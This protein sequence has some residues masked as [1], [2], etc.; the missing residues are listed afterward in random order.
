MET[1]DS[2]PPLLDAPPP[3]L[4]DF[5]FPDSSDDLPDAIP[6]APRRVVPRER[7]RRPPVE[8]RRARRSAPTALLVALPH[9]ATALLAVAALVVGAGFGLPTPAGAALVVAVGQSVGLALARLAGQD[10]VAR[11]WTVDLLVTLALV[12]LASL[13]VYLTQEPY[14]DFGQ[15]PSVR[16]PLLAAT[17]ATVAVLLV[18]AGWSAFVSRAD[19]EHASLLFLPAA[20]AAT[21]VLGTRVVEGQDDALRALIEAMALAAMVTTVAWILPQGLRPIAGPAGVGV[22]LVA[23]W[24][25]GRGPTFAA[26]SDDAVRRYGAVIVV[27][28]VVLV[29]TAPLLA[30]WARRVGLVMA[31][32]ANGRRI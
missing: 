3:R 13:Q 27:A 16:T 32:N 23:L 22:Q 7:A 10:L 25:F 14:L 31:T 26:T 2:Q 17:G 12:P 11:V 5:P 24:L 19:P 8:E 21:A 28:V 6:T 15:D 9:A 4:P 1:P 30:L 20:L 18:I 29:V